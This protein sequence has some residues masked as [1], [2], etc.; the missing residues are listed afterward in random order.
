MLDRSRKSKA[1]LRSA[2]SRRRQRLGLRVFAIELEEFPTI[3][4]LIDRGVITEDEALAP[5]AV[6]R[7]L[8]KI[9][10]A[11]SARRDA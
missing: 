2:R 1:A 11:G 5:G 8:E 3:N 9:I 7:A 10:G 4:A 6:P